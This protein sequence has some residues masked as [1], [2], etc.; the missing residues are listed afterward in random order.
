MSRLSTDLRRAVPVL[1]PARRGL[2]PGRF[3]GPR[4]V[5]LTLVT[6]WLAARRPHSWL[7]WVGTIALLALFSAEPVLARMQPRI[8]ALQLPGYR[9]AR[10]SVAVRTLVPLS[11]ASALLL[12][13]AAALRG[14]PWW[15]VAAAAGQ[16]LVFAAATLAALRSYAGRAARARELRG[17]LEAYAP[18][19]VLHTARRGS[20]Y[21]VQ[22]W[23]PL[24]EGLGRRYVILT[25]DDGALEGLTGITS[26]PV[27]ARTTWRE[28][29][30]AVVPSLRAALYVNSVAANADLVTYRQMTHVYLGHG[31]SDK[32]LSS[33][34]AHAMYDRIFVS[35]QAAVD[36]YEVNGVLIPPEKLVVVGRPQTASIA[37]ATQSVGRIAA[38]TVLYAPT[39]AGYNGATSYS[40]LPSAVALVTALLR[41]PGAVI[42]RP[43]P[44]SRERPAE[45]AH[46]AAVE[47]LLAT[48]AAATGRPHRYAESGT[49]AD[50]ANAADAMVA[51]LSSVLVEF[52]ASDKP[53]AVVVPAGESPETFRARHRV[54]EGACLIAGDLTALDDVLEDLLV[55][56]SLRGE[57]ERVL[58]HYAGTDDAADAGAAFRAALL[59]IVAP[60][61]A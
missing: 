12:A 18:E 43:H 11:L 44:F 16:A 54:A 27:V 56:D 34:P 41:R 17:A 4:T 5:A 8:G 51:D 30:D 55:R 39:W 42:F 60:G 61:Q 15:F 47:A 23:L 21:Q 33:H 35:G 50:S 36:R 20:L 10:V 3:S 49:F 24:I 58:R 29:D 52:L 1:F 26:A 22:M 13:L 14:S 28:L 59:D 2:P 53:M 6:A 45:R 57:R 38:P 40:S 19:I 48:D 46:V 25:R 32:A 31:E 9:R 7:A 37:R